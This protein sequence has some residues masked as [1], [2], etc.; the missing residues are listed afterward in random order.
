MAQNKAITNRLKQINFIEGMV[1]WFSS[2]SGAMV[3]KSTSLIATCSDLELEVEC[4]GGKTSAC[5]LLVVFQV[6]LFLFESGSTVIY[7]IAHCT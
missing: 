7:I 5:N 1:L 4:S 2:L 3:L 6:D